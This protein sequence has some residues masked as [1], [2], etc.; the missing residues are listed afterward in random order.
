MLTKKDLLWLLLYPLYQILSTIRHEGGHAL[1]AALEGAH[2]TR[3]V[4]WPSV[5]NGHFYWGYA[6]WTGHTTWLS[7]AAPYLIDLLT[8]ALA[9][10]L[11]RR[12]AH[13]PRWLWL[14]IGI[15]GLLSPLVNSAYNYIGGWVNSANDVARLL[16]LLP[17]ALVH[18]YFLLTLGLY[19]AAIWI[20]LRRSAWRASQVCG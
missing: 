20:A 13:R 9:F 12:L 14:N 3:F 17:P 5:N 19:A 16:D 6:Q 1:A 10:V 4:F 11:L 2:V 7:L 15:I 18:A 8:A